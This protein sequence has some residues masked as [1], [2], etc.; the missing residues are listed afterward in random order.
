MRFRLKILTVSLFVLVV[1]IGVYIFHR[2]DTGKSAISGVEDES[3]V[4]D[5]KISE[6]VV[7]IDSGHGGI[8]PGKIGVGGIYEKDINLA[9]S[10]KL[11][12]LLE[13]SG[14]T[15]IMTR[16]DDNGLYDDSDTNKKASDMKKRCSIINGCNAD[17]AVSI[18]Q[19]SY[20][21]EDSKGAQVFYYK[22]STEGK[23]LAGI[24]QKHVVNEVDTTNKR[25]EKAD[26][27]YYMLLHTNVP[28]V[29]VECGF[30]SNP[31]EAV[32]LN[33]DSY[34]QKIAEGIYNGLMEYLTNQ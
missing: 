26:S 2:T 11:K 21:S 31:Q 16:S 27:T 33:S 1:L 24:I 18:H 17:A 3:I 29:I 23:K 5:I 14:I 12:K 19:N 6:A 15:V 4:E 34:Q 13:Q 25:V 20:V 7:A 30:L 10:L 9:I 28:A 8:D 22:Q 32:R